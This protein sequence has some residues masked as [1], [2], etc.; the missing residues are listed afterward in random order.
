MS[1]KLMNKARTLQARVELVHKNNNKELGAIHENLE[2]VS[3]YIRSQKRALLEADKKASELTAE[4]RELKKLM[5]KF[6]SCAE[7]LI[8]ANSLSWISEVKQKC[9][10]LIDIATE[11]ESMSTEY[12]IRQ[13]QRNSQYLASTSGGNASQE[14][15]NGQYS[16][17]SF[18]PVLATG[19]GSAIGAHNNVDDNEVR[20]KG[21]IVQ[22]QTPE[23]NDDRAVGDH[24]ADQNPIEHGGLESEI[25]QPNSIKNIMRRLSRHLS[26]H[27]EFTDLSDLVDDTPSEDVTYSY[28]TLKPAVGGAHR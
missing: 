26:E 23:Q 21:D 1:D 16:S 13:S 24:S 19:G 10:T 17:P 7:F 4:N 28:T 8:E 14:V 12:V 22:V 2:E 25:P 6:V 3:K 18:A 20:I 5:G 15:Q 9:L 27:G 11:A